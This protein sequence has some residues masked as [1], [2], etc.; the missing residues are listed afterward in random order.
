[1]LPAV[2]QGAIGIETRSDNEL[3]VQSVRK[4][5]H[6]ET[7]LACLAER[8]FLRTLGGGCQYP[9]AAHG[10]VNG[11]ELQLE[12]LVAKPDG[13]RILR[14]ILSGSTEQPEELGAALAEKLNE[15]GAQSL[16]N[17]Q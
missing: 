5:E 6:H 16:L 17:E 12:G 11:Q 13:S 4:L 2:G 10:V 1:M 14:D 9:I 7:R 3:A 15:N 8:A